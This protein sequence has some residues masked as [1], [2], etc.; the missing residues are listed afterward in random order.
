MWIG[1]MYVIVGFMSDF[2]AIAMGQ[3]FLLGWGCPGSIEVSWGVM[4]VSAASV[5]GAIAVVCIDGN[6]GFTGM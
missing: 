3:V 6:G 1:Y 4:A 2:K 5:M